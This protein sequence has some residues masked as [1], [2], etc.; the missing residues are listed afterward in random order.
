VHER[1][2]WGRSQTTLP[3]QSVVAVRAG[4]LGSDETLFRRL[5]IEFLTGRKALRK[6]GLCPSLVDGS[7]PVPRSPLL[8]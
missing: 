4:A 8:F 7:Q 6:V 5:V 2:T 1:E 3:Q